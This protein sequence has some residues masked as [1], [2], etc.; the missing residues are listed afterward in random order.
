MF[1]E[2]GIRIW[3]EGEKKTGLPRQELV[4]PA[5]FLQGGNSSFPSFDF[6]EKISNALLM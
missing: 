2:I 5:A 1:R 4:H 6:S 3:G